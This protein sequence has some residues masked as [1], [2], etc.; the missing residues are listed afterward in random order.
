MKTEYV[1]KDLICN[2]DGTVTYWSVVLREWI[3]RVRAV[4]NEELIAMSADNRERVLYHLS[5][6]NRPNESYQGYS[7]TGT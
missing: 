3:M 7:A 2:R 1:T 6:H 5:R 4:P